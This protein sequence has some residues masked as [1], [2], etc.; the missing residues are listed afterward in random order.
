[1]ELELSART[2]AVH[3]PLGGE[4]TV[5]RGDRMNPES[6]LLVG[7][8]AEIFPLSGS[9]AVT[10]LHVRRQWGVGADI[11]TSWALRPASRRDWKEPREYNVRSLTSSKW[12]NLYQGVS[13]KM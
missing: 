5:I 10:F 9:S 8:K 12:A 11:R 4:V 3:R 1:M 13:T 2:S 6:K 7:L